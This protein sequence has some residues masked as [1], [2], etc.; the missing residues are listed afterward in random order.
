[1]MIRRSIDRW[2]M[3]GAPKLI[4]HCYCLVFVVIVFVLLAHLQLLRLD[5]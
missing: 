2:P 5:T 1:M 4:R 3:V